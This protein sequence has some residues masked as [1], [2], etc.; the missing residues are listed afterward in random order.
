MD[1]WQ[2]ITAFALALIAGG[3]IGVTIIHSLHERSM[4]KIERQEHKEDQREERAVL[5][6]ESRL[7][8][9][10]N[11]LQEMKE[12]SDAERVAIRYILYYQI[13]HI[14]LCYISDGEVDF[15]D[16]RILRDMHTS[17]HTGLGGNGDL[18]KL[19]EAVDELPLK[20]K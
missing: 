3:G 6:I 7:Q 5:N 1:I 19:M 8:A 20:Q 11:S 9:V 17:Y 13:R 16:R 2:F 14:A 10:E 12:R 18:D 15:D 4:H